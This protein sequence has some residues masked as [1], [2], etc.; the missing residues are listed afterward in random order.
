LKRGR[1]EE[2]GWGT[3]MRGPLRG[4]KD[5]LVLRS[6]VAHPRALCP[7]LYTR[8]INDSPNKFS[9][10]EAFPSGRHMFN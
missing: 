7:S 1:I 2:Q 9:S 4:K 6:A 5:S 3:A 10:R 8:G